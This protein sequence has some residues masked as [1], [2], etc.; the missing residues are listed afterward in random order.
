MRGLFLEEHLAQ[1]KLKLEESDRNLVDYAQSA[2]IVNLDDKQ[3]LVGA[4]LAAVNDNSR[5]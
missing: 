4:D 2:H 5:L 1:L 3:T